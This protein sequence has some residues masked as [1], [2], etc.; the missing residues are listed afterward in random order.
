M[1]GSE[2]DFLRDMLRRFDALQKAL[3]QVKWNLAVMY[4]ATPQEPPSDEQR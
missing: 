3:D 4:A 2:V 1:P